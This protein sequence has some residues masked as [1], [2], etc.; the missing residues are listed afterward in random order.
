M[1]NPIAP[2]GEMFVP[3]HSD[4]IWVQQTL[5]GGWQPGSNRS[6]AHS[7]RGPLSQ[8]LNGRWNPI[9][10]RLIQ[11]FGNVSVEDPAKDVLPCLAAHLQV[12]RQS[13]GE[14]DDSIVHEGRAR[15]YAHGHACAIDL[16]ELRV[17]ECRDEFMSEHPLQDLEF[18]VQWN[19]CKIGWR[20]LG[21]VTDDEPVTG[22]PPGGQYLVHLF[23]GGR[24]HPAG[25]PVELGARGSLP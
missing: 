14:F 22:I 1:V 12:R 20:L 19:E 5:L 24:A 10:G 6:S 8:V 16:L 3:L 11:R 21:I 4:R 9:L 18:A 25:Q 17:Y 7:L 23:L 2:A 15:F 13:E